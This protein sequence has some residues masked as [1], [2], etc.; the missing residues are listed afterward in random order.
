[1]NTSYFAKSGNHPEAVCIAA[2]PP[3]FYKGRCYPK[4]GPKPW[5]LKKYKK[6]KDE[7]FYTEQYYKEVLDKL[8]PKEVYKELG[9]DAVLICWEGSEKFCHRH[10]VAMW[11]S[12]NLGVVITEL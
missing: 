6:D 11:L 10:I 2:K 1:M 4:L 9:E 8:D 7:E 5:F 3:R 12:S